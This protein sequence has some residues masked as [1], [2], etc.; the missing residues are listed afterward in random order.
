MKELWALLY[1]HDWEPPK[2]DQEH[3]W[4]PG[5]NVFPEIHALYST[6]QEAEAVRSKMQ[7]PAGYWVRRVRYDVEQ[8]GNADGA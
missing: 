3:K 1:L 4:E 8:R 6:W 5:K 7:K 2:G